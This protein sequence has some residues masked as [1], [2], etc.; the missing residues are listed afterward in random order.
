M[1]RRNILRLTTTLITT[2]QT[3]NF[4]SLPIN[5]PTYMI[6]FIKKIFGIND[7][8]GGP[9]ISDE[10]LLTEESDI[11]A[12]VVTDLGNVRTNNEDM[13]YFVR[14]N[15]P[16]A[17]RSKGFLGIVAD[18]MGGHAAGE[19]AS[20][21]AVETIRKVYYASEE[22][23]V[24][25]LKAAF[26]AANEKINSEAQRNTQ[27]KGMG[28]TATAVVIRGD[29]LYYAH[30]GDSRLYL[31]NSEGI[32][33]LSTD[34]TYIQQ[35]LRNGEITKEAAVVHPDRNVLI[36]AMGT[37]PTVEVEV[38]KIR[39]NFG[40]GCRLLLCSDGLYDYLNDDEILQMS[41]TGELKTCA[42]DLITAAKTRGGHDNITVLI[43]ES[44]E[45]SSVEKNK[46]TTDL[47]E[48]VKRREAETKEMDL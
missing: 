26:I 27:R 45:V 48:L 17:R 23:V 14:P 19:V 32:T 15:D 47:E 37:N 3:Q 39:Q 24:K 33:Q 31:L 1:Y 29:E 42:Y 46:V 11:R 8:N 6:A 34:H 12:I 41:L 21:M 22:S 5:E 28:T 13:G 35:L 2:I 43:I 4:A 38:A 7:P 16:N 18:G 9:K 25:S 40:I 20:K 36:R 10:S 30:I 44:N